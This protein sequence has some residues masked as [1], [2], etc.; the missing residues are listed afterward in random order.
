MKKTTDQCQLDPGNIRP[1]CHPLAA[2]NQIAKLR[3]IAAGHL[4]K[5]TATIQHAVFRVDHVILKKSVGTAPVIKP[6][7]IASI[8]RFNM[9]HSL[10]AFSLKFLRCCALIIADLL[11]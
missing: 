7:T 10:F 5:I 3:A 11:R 8:P 1:N 6:A 2:S 4:G 9:A